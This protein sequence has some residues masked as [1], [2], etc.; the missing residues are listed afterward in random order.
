MS[1]I[2]RLSSVGQNWTHTHS[3]FING[4]AFLH[5]KYFFV[6]IFFLRSNL[7]ISI[8]VSL[9]LPFSVRHADCAVFEFKLVSS[10]VFSCCLSSSTLRYQFNN[11]SCAWFLM[12]HWPCYNSKDSRNNWDSIVAR[13]EEK[14]NWIAIHLNGIIVTLIQRNAAETNEDY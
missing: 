8:S 5:T 1:Y 3:R 4:R 7:F 10:F 9:S 14:K 13:W 2:R 6:T 12:H 11:Y